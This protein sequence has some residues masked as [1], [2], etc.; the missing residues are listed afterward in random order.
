MSSQLFF[1]FLHGV[2]FGGGGGGEGCSK[3]SDFQ[4]G[5][6]YKRGWLTGFLLLLE[7]LEKPW[8]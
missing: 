6:A 1:L 8:N 3:K 4:L 7:V 2:E 5:E